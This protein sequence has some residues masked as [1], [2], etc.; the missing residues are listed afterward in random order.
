LVGTNNYTNSI[1]N[2]VVVGVY[3]Y[4]GS[5]PGGMPEIS[6][7]LRDKD[8]KLVA[9]QKAFSVPSLIKPNTVIPFNVLFFDYAGDWETYDVEIQVP[10]LS[11]FM[12]DLFYADFQVEEANLVPGGRFSNGPK[13]TGVVRNVGSRIGTNVLA[14]GAVYDKDGKVLDVNTGLA[15]IS[16]LA[17][18]QSSPFEISFDASEGAVRYDIVVT[19]ITG[20]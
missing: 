16:N 5:K 3:Q 7:S 6:V 20:Q 9:A 4:N 8:G 19:A 10:P 12:P 11:T 2:P 13:I 15:T 18:G 1:G 14:Y 17:P